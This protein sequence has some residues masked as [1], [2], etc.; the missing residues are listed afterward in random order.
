MTYEQYWYGDPLM[1]RAF[2]KAEEIRQERAD[3]NAWLNGIYVVNALE[4]TVGNMFRKN[5]SEPLEY[6]KQPILASENHE[7][8]KTEQADQETAIARLYMLNMVRAGK[9][10]GKH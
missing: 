5:G 2:C 4:A 8:V 9:D 3:Y 7:E 1:V 6:P 10:W